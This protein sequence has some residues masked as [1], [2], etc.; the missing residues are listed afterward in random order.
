MVVLGFVERRGDLYQNAPIAATF[1]TGRTPTDLRPFLRFW[2]RFSYPIWTKLE[3]A[4]RTGEPQTTM[5]LP[6]ETQRIV[7]EGIAAIQAAPSQALPSTY[8]FS[9]HQRMLDLGGGHG[10]VAESRPTTV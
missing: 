4:V 5:Q 1:L 10:L 3:D 9:R 6:E 7:S 2:N 8:D